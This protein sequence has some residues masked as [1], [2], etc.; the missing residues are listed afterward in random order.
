MKVLVA[1]GKGYIGSHLVR[2]LTDGR[3]LLGERPEVVIFDNLSGGHRETLAGRCTFLEGDLRN[4]EDVARLFDKHSFDLV[5][6]FAALINVGED[7]RIPAEY[8]Y[9]NTGGSLNLANEM[10]QRGI[11]H[12]IFSSTA[13]TYKSSDGY[14]KENSTTIPKSVYGRTKLAAERMFLGFES[15]G[16][17]NPLIFRYFNVAGADPSGEI[18]E[19][20]QPELHLI[21]RVIL[22]AMTNHPT[23][24][25]GND[26][27]IPAG[28]W[29]NDGTCVRDY[30]HVMD[31]I[32]A[33]ILGAEVLLKG[34]PKHRVYNLGSKVGYSVLQIIDAVSDVTG[35]PVK[36]EFRP[37][38]G[39]DAAVLVADSALAQEELGWRRKY[40]LRDMILH[41]YN[42][43]K[44]RPD[45]VQ[46][47][48]VQREAELRA[49]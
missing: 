44:R 26:Y 24:V 19:W 8:W 18:G 33:H 31:L 41:A 1:G 25:Y 17:L 21:A 32:E 49:A 30:N 15:M 20:H 16:L 46:A 37:R 23:W 36:S 14:L 47:Y 22:D 35:L 10:A 9:N 3:G 27:P 38:R 13:A 34:K 2:E 11:Q 43:Y 6:H 39:G 28:P 29:V 45:I 4:P 12:I 40:E 7:A 42:F 48:R 5:F